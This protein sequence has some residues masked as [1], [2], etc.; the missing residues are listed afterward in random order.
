MLKVTPLC[1]KWKLLQC[2]LGVYD[3]GGGAFA[4]FLCPHP[5]AFGSMSAPTPREFAIQEKN[6]NAQGLAGGGMNAAGSDQCISVWLGWL[7][8]LS[9]LP[10]TFINY[11]QGL[12]GLSTESLWLAP[13][14]NESEM[15]NLYL[16]LYDRCNCN[17]CNFLE[18]LI[19]RIRED[20]LLSQSQ[21]G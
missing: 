9:S 12:S 11:L 4:L 14:C 1:N 5:G 17:F 2:W 21:E 16:Y 13:F 3:P 8:S 10:A 18:F 6:P 7:I 19:L 15:L 20:D